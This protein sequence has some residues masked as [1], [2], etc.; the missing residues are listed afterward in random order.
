MPMPRHRSRTY[1][2]RFVRTPGG[3]VVIHY[4]EKKAGPAKCA[5]CGRQLGGVPRLRSSELRSLPK[6]ARAPNR[7]YGGHLCPTCTRQVIK[8]AAR[9]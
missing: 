9:A 6:S 1:K 4:K 8:E 5:M 3:R 7:P 2:K